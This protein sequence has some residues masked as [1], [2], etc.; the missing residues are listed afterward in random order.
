[1]GVIPGAAIL[2]CSPRVRDSVFWSCRTLGDR[3]NAILVISVVLTDTVPVYT[4]T[5]LGV[6][7]IVRY[8]DS[9]GVAPVCEQCGTR[10]GTINSL[11]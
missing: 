8:M 2:S 3:D 11:V 7:E 4:G 1:M 5:V 10:D 9:D 6:D